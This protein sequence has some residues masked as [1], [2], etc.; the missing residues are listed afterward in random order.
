MA[1]HYNSILSNY[2]LELGSGSDYKSKF[3]MI[4]HNNREDIRKDMINYINN[5]DVVINMMEEVV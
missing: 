4:T 1:E 5:L 3:E 2:G